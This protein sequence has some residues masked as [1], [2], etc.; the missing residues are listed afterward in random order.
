[1]LFY[2]IQEIAIMLIAAIIIDWPIGDPKWLTH[3]VIYMGRLIRWLEKQLRTVE[4]LTRAEKLS[5]IFLCFLTIGFCGS[6]MWV[7]LG[8]CNNIHPWLGY[9]VNLPTFKRGEPY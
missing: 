5:G 3:P 8:I 7:I 9:V 1:M 2:S 4:A 6:L